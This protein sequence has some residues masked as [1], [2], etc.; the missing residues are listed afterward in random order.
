VDKITRLQWISEAT[1]YKA[2]ARNFAPGRE[3][4]D[5]GVVPLTGKYCYVSAR[6]D[7][8]PF[9]PPF[10]TIGQGNDKLRS[11]KYLYLPNAPRNSTETSGKLS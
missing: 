9:C 3:L 4:D 2:E 7:K 11:Q 10:T 1:Y 8:Q 6:Q 5:C